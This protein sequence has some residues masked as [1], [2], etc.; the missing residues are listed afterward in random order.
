MAGKETISINDEISPADLNLINLIKNN[1]NII[2]IRFLK[3]NEK[4]QTSLYN[5]AF[6]PKWRR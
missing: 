6:C 1:I 3:S 5:A 4:T 2:Y